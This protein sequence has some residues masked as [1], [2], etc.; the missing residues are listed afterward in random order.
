MTATSFAEVLRSLRERRGVSQL[1]LAKMAGI[2][3]SLVSRYESG[4]R[5]PTRTT[6]IKLCRALGLDT[7]DR[8]RLLAAA[9]FVLPS[10]DGNLG[11]LVSE[12][13]RLAL[14]LDRLATQLETVLG[15]NREGESRGT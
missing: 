3:H 2:H 4:S 7:A 5:W 15:T 14:E 13:R 11:V 6:V 9:G 10:M 12:L 8:M 1:R